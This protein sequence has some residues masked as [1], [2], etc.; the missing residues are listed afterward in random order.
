MFKPL[1]DTMSVSP[2]ITVAD[3]HTAAG[4]GIKAVINNR[5][6]E[7]ESGQITSAELKR[8]AEA[9]GMHY[10]H[11]PIT[12]PNITQ[13]QIDKMVIA[14]SRA[15]GSVLAFCR[16]G[17]RSTYVW[18]LAQARLSQSPDELA[19]KAAMQGYD[20]TPIRALLDTQAASVA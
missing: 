10:S 8:H 3:L 7:E 17:T 18:A 14:L 5:P 20:I 13:L 4:L 2:Q 6:D 1:D 15:E 16:S 19:A 9:L 12:L 11:I